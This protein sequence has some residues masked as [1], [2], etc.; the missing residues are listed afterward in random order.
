MIIYVA[1]HLRLIAHPKIATVRSGECMSA[2][3][4]KTSCTKMVL[5]NQVRLGMIFQEQ[6]IP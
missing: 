6:L 2:F 1:L 3:K 5:R 4:Y